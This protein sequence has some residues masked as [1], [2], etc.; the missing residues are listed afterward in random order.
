[1]NFIEQKNR[2]DILKN[3]LANTDVI[4]KKLYKYIVTDNKTTDDD[5]RIGFLFETKVH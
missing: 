5:R 4:P 2:K 1:M 3:I